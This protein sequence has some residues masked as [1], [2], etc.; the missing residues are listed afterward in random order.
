MCATVK[1]RKG[2]QPDTCEYGPVPEYPFSALSMDF[3][4]LPPRTVHSVLY[5]YAFVCVCRLTGY[6][7]SVP[8][9]KTIDARQLARLFLTRVMPV[10]GIPDKKFSDRDKLITSSFFTTLNELS[11][12]NMSQSAAYRPHANGRAEN[13]VQMVIQ[14]LRKVIAQSGKKKWP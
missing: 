8:C 11:G 13:A 14:S 3:V 9:Q 5:D 2:V 1:P 12:I 6:V 7:I 10:T 4:D